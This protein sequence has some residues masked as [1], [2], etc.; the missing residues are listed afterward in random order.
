MYYVTVKK[1]FAITDRLNLYIPVYN[2]DILHKL[3]FVLSDSL[4]FIQAGI[5]RC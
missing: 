1:T 3:S 4:G 5:E 2:A